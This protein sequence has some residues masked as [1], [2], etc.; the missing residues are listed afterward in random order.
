M[1]LNKDTLG[2]A[3]YYAS[4]NFN[5]ANIEATDD[6]AMEDYRTNFWK[7]IANELIEHLKTNGE[8][9]GNVATSGTAAAQTGSIVAGTGKIQ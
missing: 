4:K 3:L 8:I 9:I 2:V 7:A 5:D 6:E 1:A